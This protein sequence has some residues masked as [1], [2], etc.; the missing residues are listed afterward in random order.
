L[1]DFCLHSFAVSFPFEN[2]WMEHVPPC[3]NHPSLGAS[4]LL[5]RKHRGPTEI[6][7]REIKIHLT[8]AAPQRHRIQHQMPTV[9]FCGEK[10]TNATNKKSKSW[11]SPLYF[12]STMSESESSSASSVNDDAFDDYRAL[13]SSD[14]PAILN[15]VR[16][17]VC[18]ELFTV[19]SLQVG[20]LEK[21]D[22]FA[23]DKSLDWIES[24]SV[25][26]QAIVGVAA[27]DD[28]KREFTL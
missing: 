18:V 7:E 21:L 9:H 6:R 2:A 25:T 22:E 10:E 4:G 5:P 15:K 14:R 20:L 24:Q 27:D 8:T 26:G 23:F 1:F 3:E 19:Y 16:T 11:D 13:R 12:V 28:L 17:L